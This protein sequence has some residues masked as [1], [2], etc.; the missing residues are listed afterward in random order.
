MFLVSC[1][2]PAAD[3]KDKF[4]AVNKS[5]DSADNAMNTTIDS[6]KLVA[7]KALADYYARGGTT[8]RL[9]DSVAFITF[10]FVKYARVFVDS[11]KSVLA[12]TDNK[13]E[14]LDVATELLVGTETGARLKQVLLEVYTL[15]RS[16]V[17]DPKTMTEYDLVMKDIRS[18]QDDKE[19]LKKYF[20]MTPTVGAI[21]IL[22]KLENDCLTGATIIVNQY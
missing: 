8:E 7:K 13:G 21:T 19:W 3:G 5:L 6:N 2:Y 14:K 10:S 20:H 11:L 12:R 22:T 15:C 16:Y 4:E 1:K 18:I 17:T 9:K